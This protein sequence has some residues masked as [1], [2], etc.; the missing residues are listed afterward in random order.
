[1]IRLSSHDDSL[2]GSLIT[3]ETAVVA[4]PFHSALRLA[5][6]IRCPHRQRRLGRIVLSL[7]TNDFSPRRPAAAARRAGL[8]PFHGNRQL[9]ARDPFPGS[10]LPGNSR[11]EVFHLRPSCFLLLFHLLPCARVTTTPRYAGFVSLHTRFQSPYLPFFFL[12]LTT[13]LDTRSGIHRSRG[14]CS[15]LVIPSWKK[16]KKQTKE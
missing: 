14:V 8:F 7:C 9:L 2:E 6:S 3:V 13:R 10:G 11:G 1:M 12:R 4:P 16:K 15:A 5:S